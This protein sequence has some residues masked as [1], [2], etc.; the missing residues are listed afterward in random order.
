MP[1]LVHFIGQEQPVPLE[2]DYDK[3]NT[4]LHAGEGGQFVR[5]IGDNRSRVTIYK[6]AIAYIEETEEA[7]PFAASF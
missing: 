5:A 4:Q 2:E 1:T 7:K 6:S 3:V